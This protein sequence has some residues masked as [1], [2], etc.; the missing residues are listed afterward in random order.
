[1]GIELMMACHCI[2][3]VV[4]RSMFLLEIEEDVTTYIYIFHF[5]IMRF[6]FPKMNRS[7]A[8]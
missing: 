7:M 1:M 8:V 5:V 2:V 4:V 6:V 3:V